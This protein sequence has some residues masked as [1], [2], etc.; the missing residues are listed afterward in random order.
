MRVRMFVVVE[1]VVEGPGAGGPWPRVVWP[2]VGQA[3]TCVEAREM[4]CAWRA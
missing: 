2:V 1:C 4:V 3:Q